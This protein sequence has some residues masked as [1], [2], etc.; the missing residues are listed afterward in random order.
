ML[1]AQSL[2]MSGWGVG[3]YDFDN[4]GRKDLFTANSHVS[5]NAEYY[6]SQH[7]YRQPNAVFRNEGQGAFKDV[8]RLAGAAMRS[9]AAH[10]GS[11]FG[12][13]DNDG[14]IDAVVSAIGSPA[15]ILYNT[16][17]GNNHWVL[18]QVEGRIDNRDGIGT[19]IK[20]TGQSGLTQFNHVTTAVS[21]ASSSD[22]RV[23]FGMGSD[24]TIREIELRWPSGKVQVLR[25]VKCDRILKVIEE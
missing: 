4:D 16:S 21:Y 7:K 19:K 6:Y 17:S 24:T 5:E 12:D 9:A 11:A 13:L 8:T 14:R 23:H 2:T 22:K 25:N 18:I 15:E 10:R 3:A 1:G 20:V